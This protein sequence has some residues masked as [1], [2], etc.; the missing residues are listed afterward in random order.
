MTAANMFDRQTLREY[1]KVIDPRILAKDH[2]GKPTSL[3]AVF[4]TSPNRP[5]T[6]FVEPRPHDK[7]WGLSW[8]RKEGPLKDDDG[9]KG[10]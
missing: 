7:P 6:N 9:P 10:A 5:G 1:T 3:P 2:L 4:G 8:G